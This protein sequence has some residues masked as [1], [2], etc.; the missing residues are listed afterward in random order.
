MSTRSN[1]LS[2]HTTLMDEAKEAINKLFGDNT[3]DRTTTKN[4]LEEIVGDIEIMLET[5]SGADE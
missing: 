4:D 2:K 3:V 5:L 1:K